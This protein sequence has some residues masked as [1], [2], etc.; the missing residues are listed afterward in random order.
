MCP[1]GNENFCS[2]SRGEEGE[3][4][5]GRKKCGF[6]RNERFLSSGVIELFTE[7]ISNGPLAI[8]GPAFHAIGY[9]VAEFTFKNGI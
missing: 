4:Q 6:K 1:S 5:K 3:F 9:Q 7:K 8:A 2:G